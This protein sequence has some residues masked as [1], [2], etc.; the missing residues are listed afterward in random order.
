MKIVNNADL[1][2]IKNQPYPI[3]VIKEVKGLLQNTNL[4]YEYYLL[5]NILLFIL[6]IYNNVNIYHYILHSIC[7]CFVTMGNYK[8]DKKT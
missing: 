5:P 7:Q 1:N 4:R 6:S 3:T 2:N 8:R